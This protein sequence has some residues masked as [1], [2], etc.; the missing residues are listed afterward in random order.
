[1]VS[2]AYRDSTAGLDGTP[3]D[4]LFGWLR[5]ELTP[6]ARV[7]DLGCGC[8]VPLTKALAEAANVVGVDF[9]GVQLRRARQL[10]PPAA[11]LLRADMTALEFKPGAFRAV[12]AA[13]SIIHVPLECQPA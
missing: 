1:C 2:E 12:V 5:P 4:E 8:G 3:Y 7:L 10:L 13:Y 11:A 6:E 9:S